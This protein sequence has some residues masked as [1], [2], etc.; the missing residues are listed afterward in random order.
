MVLLF[1]LRLL[2]LLRCAT[3]LSRLDL[4]PGSELGCVGIRARRQH[5]HT[6]TYTRS[7]SLA[8]GPHNSSPSPC[9]SHLFSAFAL[10]L[11]SLLFPHHTLLSSNYHLKLYEIVIET[12]F[13][14]LPIPTQ[15]LN[16]QPQSS[17]Q[18]DRPFRKLTHLPPIQ[19][20]AVVAFTRAC[21]HN[22]A[23]CDAMRRVFNYVAC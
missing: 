19:L 21:S 7:R 6:H 1:L 20:C 10:L 5:T 23:G 3:R 17:R 15:V 11:F 14:F 9:P 2:V 8:A 22:V 18:A 13:Y 12:T 16:S 4:G